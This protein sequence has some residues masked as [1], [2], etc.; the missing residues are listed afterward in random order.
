MTGLGTILRASGDTVTPMKVGLITN[1][2]NLF[3]DYFLIFGIGSW[4]GLGIVGT[5]LGT[6]VA[7][8]LGNILLLG[9]LRKTGLDLGWPRR[10]AWGEYRELMSLSIPAALE[11]LVMRLGQVVYFSL[12]VGL[13]ATVYA[14]HM[15]AGSIESF[16]YMP[17]YGLAT[18]AAILV[19]QA[20]GKGDIGLVRRVARLSSAY[21]VGIMSLLGL[22]LYVAAPSLALLFTKDLEA[23]QQVVTALRIAAFN[24]PGLAVSLIMAG[25]LQGMG[26]TQSPLYSTLV[27]MWGLRVVGVIVLGQILGLG[28]A[29]VWLAILV[30]LVLRAVFLSWRFSKQIGEKERLNQT[31]SNA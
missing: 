9:Q 30:D 10:F 23:V 12:I 31:T 3:L 11:R 4:P 8:L 26:D 18:A 7:R 17:A 1:F 19:G 28:I 5:A 16:T 2:A 29:G 14:S 25:V 15:I 24:Q 21:G 13:G 27:G 6:I 22:V 20:L